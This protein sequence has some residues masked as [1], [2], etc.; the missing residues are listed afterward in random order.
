MW[1]LRASEPQKKGKEE[2]K[3]FFPFDNQGD[4]WEVTALH[5]SL[6]SLYSMI[7]FHMNY[8]TAFQGR[9]TVQK[10]KP[11]FEIEPN[12][13]HLKMFFPSLLCTNRVRSFHELKEEEMKAAIFGVS[14]SVQAEGHFT[15]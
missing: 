15:P 14:H 6:Y 9:C 12:I 4:V 8:Y 3:P 5:Y 7:F 2:N 1:E 11:S 13:S 10:G